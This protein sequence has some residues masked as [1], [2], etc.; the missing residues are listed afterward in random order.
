MEFSE[1]LKS[2]SKQC[3][4]PLESL[5]NN[6]EELA[7]LFLRAAGHPTVGADQK[8]RNAANEGCL[9]P[10]RYPAKRN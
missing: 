4:T 2:I 7:Q 10:Q 9:T 1:F 6:E 3:S 8:A 5:S